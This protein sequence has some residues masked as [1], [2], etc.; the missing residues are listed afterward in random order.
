MING[1]LYLVDMQKLSSAN[2]IKVKVLLGCI[3]D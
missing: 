1:K 3:P 2:E